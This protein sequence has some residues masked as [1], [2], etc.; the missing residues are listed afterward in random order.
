MVGLGAALEFFQALGP[1]R[2]YRRIHD[3][4]GRVR[5]R[6]Q[7]YPELRLA[8]ASADAFY[9]GLVSFEPIKGDL[10][11][12]VEECAARNI[13]IAGGPQR[14]RVATHVFTQPTELQAFFD[15]LQRGLRG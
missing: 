3:L 8:N 7:A 9:G 2:V 4:A 12:V 10:K 15:A 13:R 6:V 5:E 11:R 14:I 1:E